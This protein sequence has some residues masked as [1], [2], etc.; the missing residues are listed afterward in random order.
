MKRILAIGL[1]SR[2]WGVCARRIPQQVQFAERNGNQY[3]QSIGWYCQTFGI[4]SQTNH[5]DDH[6]TKP[7]EE[8][9]LQM[10]QSNDFEDAGKPVLTKLNS[11]SETDFNPIFVNKNMDFGVL[12]T[13][14]D[15]V[16][17]CYR[18]YSAP[19]G[20]YVRIYTKDMMLV[21]M[22]ILSNECQYMKLTLLKGENV[23]NFEALNEG[24]SYPNTGELQVF[25]ENGVLLAGNRWGLETGFKGVLSV[26]KE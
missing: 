17:I 14:S 1:F 6:Q 10:L 26:Y 21:P 12:K 20:D 22:A 15:F 4:Q 9:P 8:K 13:K 23:I 25:D 2:F 19:D 18:D 16:R 24:S 7:I 5:H 3:A 11:K